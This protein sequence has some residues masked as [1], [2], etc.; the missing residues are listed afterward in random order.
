MPKAY[1]KNPRKISEKQMEALRRDLAEL[2]DLSG[3]VHDLNTDEIVGGNQRSRVFDL[4]K[5]EI[6]LTSEQETPDE[7]GTVGLG[8]VVWQGKRYAYRAVR[9]DA[10]T[11][12]KANIVANKAGGAWDLDVLTGSFEVDDLLEWG[13]EPVELGELPEESEWA[14]AFDGLPDEDRAPFQQVTFTLH[15]AQVEQVKRALTAA[16]KLGDFADSPNENSNGNALAF[17]CETF[18]T[19]HGQS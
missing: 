14:D 6:V 16:G 10:K 8:Y 11:C 15:D 1:H 2:G 12:E 5:C 13:F 19:E 3:I 7:Q 18:N 4:G 17:I 9:W